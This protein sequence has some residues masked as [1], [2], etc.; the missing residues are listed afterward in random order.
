MDSIL[1]ALLA[2][3]ILV[4]ASLT[5]GRSSFSS[6]NTLTDAWQDAEE[7]TVERVQSD[8]SITSVAVL[9]PIV[10]VTIR[11]DGA[12]SLVD[13]SRMDVVIQYTSGTDSYVKYIDFTAEVLQP[14]DTWQ[15]VSI[16]DDV[17]DPGIVNSSERLN[18]RIKLNPAVGSGS[19][20]LQVTTELGVSA[21]SFFTN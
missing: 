13:Y 1:P 20:W 11:N 10:D 4:L 5:L 18:I 3:S 14:D 17:I 16:S 6:F 8:I 9:G 2:V 7:Q 12:T 21:S 19:H 15:V